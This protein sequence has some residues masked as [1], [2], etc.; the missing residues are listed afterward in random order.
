[1]GETSEFLYR[2][3]CAHNI[4]N[5]GILLFKEAQV[6]PS[7]DSGLDGACFIR[8]FHGG[9][10]PPLFG[11]ARLALASNTRLNLDVPHG[12]DR[13][14]E[15]RRAHRNFGFHASSLSPMASGRIHAGSPPGPRVF[16]L[17]NGFF[18]RCREPNKQTEQTLN[19]NLSKKGSFTPR[20]H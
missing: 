9:E 13:N 2:S 7:H 16:S 11:C 6:E 5:H 20:K 1:M 14:R 15:D 19:K 3:A 10:L 8:F 12:L 18:Q 4:R 17:A